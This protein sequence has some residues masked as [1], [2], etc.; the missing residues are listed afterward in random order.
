MIKEYIKSFWAFIWTN[1]CSYY[2]L[3]CRARL[4]R[5]L[6]NCTAASL[7]IR[8]MSSLSDECTLA[9]YQNCLKY[10]A[11]DDFECRKN[12]S[13]SCKREIYQWKYDKARC[14]GNDNHINLILRVED[15]GYA[16]FEEEYEWT[17]EEFLGEF[18]GNLGLW[19]GLDV[20]M[21]LG[22]IFSVVFVNGKQLTAYISAKIAG[23]A[24]IVI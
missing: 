16:I 3:K 14:T 19:M 11:S 2:R 7:P 13:R 23:N 15:F 10:Y 18:G 21:V 6:C 24:V 17:F 4:I 22:E 9:V 5:R 8:E 12:C 20:K 1:S